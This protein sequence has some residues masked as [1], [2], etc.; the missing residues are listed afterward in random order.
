MKRVAIFRALLAVTLLCLLVLTRGATARSGKNHHRY[1][2]VLDP[3]HGGQMHWGDESGAVSPDGTLMEKTMTLKVALATATDLR[4]AGYRVFL[5]RTTDR[6]VN[7][8]PRDWNHDGRIDHLDEMNA[9]TVFANQHHADVFVSIHF[10][11]S[12]NESI[13]GTHGFYCPD[14]PFSRKNE[15]LANLL[16]DSV[17]AAA[18]RAGY[19][20]SN[21]GVETDVADVVPQQWPDYPW[22]LVLG[23]S[24]RHRVV[25]T[26]MPGALIE[27]LYMSSPADDAAMRR[28]AIVAALA[29]GYANG[30]RA[31]FHDRTHA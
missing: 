14:R 4:A 20:D 21:G 9:R 12:T 25:A 15:R 18:R 10:D 11:G 1:I 7:T 8:P 5:T 23:P 2:V 30:I 3:G 16:N 26:Q 19:P 28:P 6:H 24:R 22:F 17:V 13:R 29:R 31:Y 27:T